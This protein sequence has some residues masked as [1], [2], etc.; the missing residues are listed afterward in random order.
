MQVRDIRSLDVGM[1]RVFDE[2]VREKNVSRVAARLFLSQSAVSG[3]LKRLRETFDDP[4]F[5]RTVTGVEPTPYALELAPH[6]EAALRSLQ[7]LLNVGREFNFASSD[8][9]LRVAG[10]DHA[11]KMMMPTL[12]ETIDRHQSRMRIFWESP[13]YL[14]LADLL[15]KGRIDVAVIPRINAWPVGVEAEV[16]YEDEYV[17]VRGRSDR[18]A[19]QAEITLD[20]YCEARHVVLG[21]SRSELEESIEQTLRAQG[22]D[23]NVVAATPAFDSLVRIVSQSRLYSVLPK[24]VAQYYETLLEIHALPFNLPRYR[25]FICWNRKSNEDLA[26]Q[27]LVRE[28]RAIAASANLSAAG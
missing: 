20:E 5:K 11:C 3:T 28:I 2:L 17:L 13:D 7:S 22:R 26:I 10:S 1:L 19:P 14:D 24:N 6:V 21:Q 25:V 16:L 23:W 8:R 27:W 12:A 9:I 15:H 4:L 18:P